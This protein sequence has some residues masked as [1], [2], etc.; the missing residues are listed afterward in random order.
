MSS[1]FEFTP[2]PPAPTYYPTMQEFQ[3]PLGYIAKIR[4]EAENYGICKIKPPPVSFGNHQLWC[5][6]LEVR[7]TE[8]KASLFDAEA[9]LS[10]HLNASGSPFCSPSP[11]H[12]HCH[13]HI[14]YFFGHSC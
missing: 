10:Q 1:E 14:T 12:F 11:L 7:W 5:Y 9:I 2:P 8:T 3:D 13:I 4:S 6:G